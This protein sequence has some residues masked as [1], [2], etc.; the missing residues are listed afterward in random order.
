MESQ[1]LP[2][3]EAAHLYGMQHVL[4]PLPHRIY[5]NAA[6]K[7]AGLVAEIAKTRK[8]KNYEVLLAVHMFTP[9]AVETSGVFGPETRDFL[10]KLSSRVKSVTLEEKSHFYLTQ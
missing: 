6:T 4:T 9:I 8:R 7:D 1:L 5:I 3:K 2:G 10:H